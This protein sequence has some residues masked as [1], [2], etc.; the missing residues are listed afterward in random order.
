V[1][2]AGNTFEEARAEFPVLERVAYLNAGSMGPVARPTVQ[3]MIDR[4]ARDR[5]RGRSGEGFLTEMWELRATARSL[6][7]D[8]LGVPPEGV[9]LTA[10]TTNGCGIVCTGLRLGAG[11]EVVTTDVEHFGL[12]GPL[13]ATGARVRVAGVR[14]RPAEEALEAILAEVGPRTKLLALSHVAWTTG[15][16]LPV[17]ELKR[18][19]QLPMLVDGA[20][21]AGAIPVDVSPFDYYTVS[22]Q[23]WP[24]GP[25]ATGA[26]YVADPESLQVM[27]PTYLSQQRYE[28]D[29]SFEPRPGADRFDAG[30]V[31]VASL[32]GL[33]AALRLPPSWRFEH[34]RA[35]AARCRELISERFEIVT[36][37]SQSTLV[38]W[39]VPNDP[40]ETAARLGQEG[41]VV[42]NV[43]G[44]PWLRASCGYWTSEED[45][46]RLVQA[47]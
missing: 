46:E 40:V 4:L 7:A 12:L 45:L 38:T 25:D 36:A 13:H 22:G 28:L 9:A 33:E 21:T 1:A 24:C 34:A 35:M 15:N 41:V 20:Q 43:P 44:T 3:A 30:W 31:P 26:L 29:G 42:R 11:D 19:T 32:A 16:E 37:P 39:S 23:K 5:E 14:D 2:V 6:I 17:H 27:A 47:L 8:L 18:E 10:S